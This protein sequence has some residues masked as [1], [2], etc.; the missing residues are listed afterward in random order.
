VEEALKQAKNEA[1]QANRAKSIFLANMSHEIRTPMNAILGYSQLLHQAGL[2]TEQKTNVDIIMRSGEHLLHLINDI[3]EMSKIESGHLQFHPSVFDLHGL[4]NDVRLMISVKATSKGLHLDFAKTDDVPRFISTDE[5]KLRQ[6]LINLLGNAVKFTDEG[7]VALTIDARS[8]IQ[9][10]NPSEKRMILL[11]DVSDSGPGMTPDDLSIIF[12]SFEQTDHG[13]TMEGTGLGLAIC[14]EYLQFL[15]GDI[16]AE[17]EPGKGSVFHVTLPVIEG[18]LE[19]MEPSPSRQRV[20]GLD[21]E[22]APVRILVVDDKEDNR[23][24]LTK[25]LK[26]VGF[27]VREAVNGMECIPASMHGIPI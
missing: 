17:S 2:P 10:G 18:R 8:E 27:Q 26:R 14:R 4:L 11:M 9:G 1:D 21:P 25:M 19:Y 5:G 20:I 3:L 15:G 16:H 7:Y 6:I 22:H 24:L 12:Q 23:N 13:R